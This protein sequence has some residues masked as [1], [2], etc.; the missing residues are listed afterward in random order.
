MIAE[1][2][3]VAML[4]ALEEAKKTP[5]AIGEYVGHTNFATYGFACGKLTA[6][7]GDEAVIEKA[8]GELLRWKSEGIVDI[9]RVFIL[10]EKLIRRIE[11][12]SELTAMMNELGIGT[13]DDSPTPGCDCEYCKK[14]TPE[15]HE[16]ARKKLEAAAS[17]PPETNGTAGFPF[18]DFLNSIRDPTQEDQ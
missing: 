14:F 8:D 6:Y 13:P 12:I 1:C 7:E 10:A 9:K 4:E 18:N 11:V 2:T 5:I 16:E 15:Q 17:P 3:Y